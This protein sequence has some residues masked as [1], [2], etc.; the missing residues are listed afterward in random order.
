[1]SSKAVTREKRGQCEGGV[2]GR[3]PGR[4]FARRIVALVGL[5]S[6]VWLAGLRSS[7]LAA[8]PPLPSQPGSEISP[9]AAQSLASKIALLSRN[10]TSASHSAAPIQI[11]E[12]EA[13]SYLKFRGHEFLPPAVLNP[14][15]HITPQGISG[16]A[17]VDFDK[18]GEIAAATDDWGARIMAV[19]FKGKQHVLATG[20]LETSGGKGK[21]TIESLTIGATSIP[22]G[23][24]NFMV[25]NYVER[26]YGLDLSKPFD[27]PQQ[28][29]YIEMGSGQAVFH[30]TA[31]TR[32]RT[33]SSH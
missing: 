15:I 5:T 18:L 16:T 17:D 6:W 30:R 22:A 10:G 8:S 25:Q 7:R 27:L 3:R 31:T 20:K 28:V 14:E 24:V 1:M 29:S 12:G 4:R 26:K 11:S 21:V 13:N 32:S 19:I 2:G 23:F 33:P 9:A